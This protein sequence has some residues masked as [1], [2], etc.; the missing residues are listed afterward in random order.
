M[1]FL[2]IQ[3]GNNAQLTNSTSIPINNSLQL[4]PD[5]SRIVVVVDPTKDYVSD[6]SD[7]SASD[8]SDGEEGS[9]QI[10]T[11]PPL[12]PPMTVENNT[13]I[14]TAVSAAN[15]STDANDSLSSI[16]V[17]NQREHDGTRNIFFCQFCDT[18][19][20]DQFECSKHEQSHESTNPHQCNFCPYRCAGRNTIIAHIKEYH[21]PSKP[22]VCIQCNKKFGRRSDL[23]KHSIVHTGVRPFGCPECGK[24]FSRNTNLTKHLRIHSGLKPHVC[25]QCP[26]SFTTK[27]DLYRHTQVHTEAK[28]FQCAK[29]P[30]T[31]SRR[32]KFLLHER[33]HILKEE[34]ENIVV[35]LNPFH[36]NVGQVVGSSN[37]LQQHQQQQYNQPPLVNSVVNI[38]PNVNNNLSQP[39][40]MSLS[41]IAVDQETTVIQQQEKYA[42]QEQQYPQ[43]IREPIENAIGTNNTN[44]NR[45]EPIRILVPKKKII[46]RPKKFS[47][48][49]C[50]KRFATQSSLMNHKN[51]HLGLRNHVCLL[52]DKTF[53]RKRELDRHSVIHTGYKP[54][55]CSHCLK[56]FGR[57]DKLVRHER[58]HMEEKVYSCT[59][60]SLMFQRN[61]ALLLHMKIHAKIPTAGEPQ[62]IPR[63][64]PMDIMTTYPMDASLQMNVDDNLSNYMGM[65][66]IQPLVIN[67]DSLNN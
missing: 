10:V 1:P 54:Y 4:P 35:Q 53:A 7:S 39:A 44:V 34:S 45:V 62:T 22:F 60:C 25:Q 38:A 59:Q 57:K 18:A 42:Q 58:I 11:T 65:S 63:T 23:K 47:C 43:I 41:A 50:P 56:N 52:C 51:V 49:I 55:S 31:F 64:I 37:Q 5:D 8:D 12:P 32:D 13:Q 24:N 14:A 16:T 20:I 27:G 48:D 33:S 40:F 30:S 29:C 61:D 28:P 2:N 15:N 36:N 9:L 21:E 46:A 3:T 66:L 26:R 67:R 6:A 17:S 19:F